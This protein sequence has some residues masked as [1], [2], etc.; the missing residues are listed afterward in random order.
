MLYVICIR[1]W[2]TYIPI[3]MVIGNELLEYPTDR[4]DSI[5]S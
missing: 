5:L 4:R 2:Y 1:R 3:Y